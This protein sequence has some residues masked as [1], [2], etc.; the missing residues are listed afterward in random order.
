[1]ESRPAPLD[2]NPAPPLPRSLRAVLF[3]RDGTLVHDVPYNND[4]ELVRPLPGARELLAALRG[5]G[6]RCAVVSN[7]SGVARGLITP[8]E[9]AAVNARVERLLGPFDAFLH[10]PHG[11]E[12]RCGCRKPAPGMLLEACRRLDVP[13]AEAVMVGDIGADM[14]AAAAAGIASVMVPTAVTMQLEVQA[15]PLVAGS[16]EE[17][18][19]LLL[20]ATAGQPA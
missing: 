14:E 4:P 7:Q 3:D 10:C 15:A 17:L 16:L 12:D 13:P 18:A 19:A 11:P 20:P 8:D 1:M 5:R 6:V 2:A 9:L